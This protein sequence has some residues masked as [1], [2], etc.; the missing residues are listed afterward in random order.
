MTPD[1]AG[2]ARY[3]AAGPDNDDPYWGV[4]GLFGALQSV[5][6]PNGTYWG[7]VYDTDGYSFPAGTDYTTLPTKSPDLK[8]LIYPTGGSMSYP[9]T[10]LA[11]VGDTI[12][13]QRRVM[14]RQGQR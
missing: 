5:V 6:L 12:V 13:D 4:H 10:A 8:R 11:H 7:C 1:V 2:A 3:T 14:T 9:A